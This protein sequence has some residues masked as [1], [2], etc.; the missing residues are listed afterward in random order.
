MRYPDPYETPRAWGPP[1]PMQMPRAWG[2]PMPPQ[3]PRAWGPRPPRKPFAPFLGFGPPA[4]GGMTG[5]K[6][7]L[8]PDAD[9]TPP[10][11]PQPG[12]PMPP[13]HPPLMPEGGAPPPFMGG[14]LPPMQNTF[15]DVDPNILQA[16]LGAFYQR[17]GRG[18]GGLR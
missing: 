16:I 6:G 2:P 10:P 12:P 14:G 17:L 7:P 13:P 11:I 18:V 15:P 4:Q 5:P 1:S 9:W 8:M 3:M